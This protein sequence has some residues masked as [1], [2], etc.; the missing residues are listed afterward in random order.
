MALLI[1]VTIGAVAGYFGGWVDMLIQRVI[2]ILQSLPTI[3]IWLMMTAA[4]PQDWPPERVFLAITIILAFIGVKMI[5]EALHGNGVD[6]PEVSLE[7]SLAV[8]VLTLVV[9]A[10]TSLAATRNTTK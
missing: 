8:I 10:I 3:P 9:T 5:L 7:I 6:V 1:G 2:E 4:L